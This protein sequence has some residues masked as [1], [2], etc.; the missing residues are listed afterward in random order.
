M[1]L[2][3][4]SY[5]LFMALRLLVAAVITAVLPMSHIWWGHSPEDAGIDGQKAVGFI[6]AF[7]GV[8]LG[9]VAVYFVFACVLHYIFRKRPLVAVDRPA[10]TSQ[11]AN[12]VDGR[13]A[14]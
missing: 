1:A 12:A 6:V 7:I 2:R 8:G 3:S 14:R 4:N 11:S 10:V 13:V 9:V 5:E